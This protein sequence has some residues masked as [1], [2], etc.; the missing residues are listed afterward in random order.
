VPCPENRVLQK[1]YPC[2]NI[3][4]GWVWRLFWATWAH[5]SAQSVCDLPGCTVNFS[6][7]VA[8]SFF[9]VCALNSCSWVEGI[10]ERPAWERSWT[11]DV[12]Q[13]GIL[14]C[15]G[16]LF[17]V[18]EIYTHSEFANHHCQVFARL[19]PAPAFFNQHALYMELTICL[20]AQL[21]TIAEVW[22]RHFHPGG[23]WN[24]FSVKLLSWH[25]VFVTLTLRVSLH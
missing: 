9:R 22:Q 23:L 14:V 10:H 4:S 24:S 8:R 19:I 21:T 20:C 6:I 2:H 16:I 3:R 5:S 25:V 7:I 12:K 13:K 15:V 18:W 17:V 1:I 11:R